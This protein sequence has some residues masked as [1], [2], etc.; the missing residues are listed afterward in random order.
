M[1]SGSIRPLECLQLLE[2]GT[3]APNPASTCLYTYSSSWFGRSS[4][5]ALEWGRDQWTDES[6]QFG[7]VLLSGVNG[8]NRFALRRSSTPPDPGRWSRDGGWEDGCR[9]CCRSNWSRDTD[10]NPATSRTDP[11]T[12]TDNRAFTF[13]SMHLADALH[14]N[15][16][17]SVHA[18]T[19]K[20]YVNY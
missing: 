12:Q 16:I 19:G 1:C 13:T 10:L 3:K 6:W 7:V 20:F 8:R 2:T 17:C 18:C 4:E 15:Y 14:L 5:A 11:W 9:R